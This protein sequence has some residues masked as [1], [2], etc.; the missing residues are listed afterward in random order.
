MDLKDK[1]VVITGGASGLGQ[2]TAKYLVE[3][4]GA[5]VGILDVN[6]EA[7][8]ATVAEL[9]EDNAIFCQTD[10]TNEESVDAALDAIVDRF[11]A[12]HGDINAAGISMPFKM[13]DKEGKAS[14]LKK[15]AMVIGINLIGVYNV[16]AKCA[17]RMALNEPDEKGERGVIINISS[18][19]AFEG[20]IGQTAYSGSKAGINGMNIPA[21]RELGPIGIRV[22]S[23]APGLFGTPMLK[24]A[25]EKLQQHLISMIEAPQRM[26]DMEE[27]AHTCTFLIENA[28]MNGRVI[29][30]DAASVMPAK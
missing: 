27:F 1:V 18:G 7:G 2:A 28:Y 23:I 25:P 8:D 20:Q 10:V 26:G 9:G 14:A 12:I 6:A 29:R 17:E 16:M 30:L 11:G 5:K 3:E 19:A 13:L 22:N 21:A 4:K 15:Y 24:A